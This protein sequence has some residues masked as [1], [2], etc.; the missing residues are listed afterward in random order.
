MQLRSGFTFLG[1]AL[2]IAAW[3]TPSASAQGADLR[4]KLA[5]DQQIRYTWSSDSVQ[6]VTLVGS[7]TPLQERKDTLQ[8]GLRAHVVKLDET[9]AVV[10]L[11]YQSLK[12][13]SDARSKTVAFDSASPDE[14]DADNPMAAAFRPLVGAK[15]QLKLDPTGKI[16]DVTAPPELRS[17]RPQITR[18]RL[19]LLDK[20]P[21]QAKFG[22]IFS[23]G[24]NSATVAPE[25]TW[26]ANQSMP[27]EYGG[28]IEVKFDNKLTALN[29]ADATITTTGTAIA[30]PES[31]AGVAKI[32]TQDATIT[33]T[34][35]WDTKAGILKNADAAQNVAMEIENPNAS[36]SIHTKAKMTIQR[37]D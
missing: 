8:I 34:S 29:G 10:E 28:T 30:K 21:V 22:E 17:G 1:F 2:T 18:P 35:T 7:P 9:G 31:D 36:L 12:I 4:T 32:K 20:A 11:E 26:T 5:I 27:M 3:Q 23:S 19:Q 16:T 33:R 6:T 13:S 14:G 25:A 24:N 15:L 37:V